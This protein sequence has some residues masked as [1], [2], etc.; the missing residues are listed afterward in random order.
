MLAFVSPMV[1]MVHF[2]PTIMI[3][4]LPTALGTTIME[5]QG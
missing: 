3:T 5:E 4:Y 1:Q 2:P